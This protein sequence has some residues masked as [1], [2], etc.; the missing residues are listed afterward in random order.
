MTGVW[1]RLLSLFD[2]GLPGRYARRSLVFYHP[3]A[4]AHFN[5]NRLTQLLRV[6]GIWL[7]INRR[8]QSGTEDVPNKSRSLCRCPSRYALRP[9]EFPNI[10]HHV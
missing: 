9:N 1:V 7:Q 3:R 2:Q 8:H 5:G 6:K 10:L 4:Q